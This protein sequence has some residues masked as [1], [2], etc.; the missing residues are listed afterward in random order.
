MSADPPR[1]KRFPA[2]WSSVGPA[3]AAGT[4][5]EPLRPQRLLHQAAQDAA[6]HVVPSGRGMAC[7]QK[8]IFLISW[9]MYQLL[10]LPAG[11]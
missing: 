2:Q 9:G 7:R 3:K 5:R 1:A 6:R 10:R 4:A 11:K 8:A